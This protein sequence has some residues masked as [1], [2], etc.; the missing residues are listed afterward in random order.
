MERIEVGSKPTS[1]IYQYNCESQVRYKCTST[2]M[3]H[4]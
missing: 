2:E 4:F 3:K 1:V